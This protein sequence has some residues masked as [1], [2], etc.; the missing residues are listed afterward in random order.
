MQLYFEFNSVLECYFLDSTHIFK[1]SNKKET[2][3]SVH[4]YHYL[5]LRLIL[6]ACKLMLFLPLS[7]YLNMYRGGDIA[8]GV[9]LYARV[10]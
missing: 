6:Y 1:G 2:L 3:K 7:M 4:A 5:L 8:H 10:Y 9:F